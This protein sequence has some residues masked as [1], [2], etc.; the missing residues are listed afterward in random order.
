ML[1]LFLGL[2]PAFYNR[3]FT[4]IAALLPLMLIMLYFMI[5][6]WSQHFYKGNSDSPKILASSLPFSIFADIIV[7][8]AV[9]WAIR[10]TAASASLHRILVAIFLQIIIGLLLIAL[11]AASLLIYYEISNGQPEKLTV[12]IIQFIIGF[13]IFSSIICILFASAFVLIIAHRISWPLIDRLIYSIA[14][15][16]VVK[17]R[18]LLGAFATACIVFAFQA[19]LTLMR[20]FITT[21]GA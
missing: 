6:I 17:N 21:L 20:K 16:Q 15:H 4:R 12:R 8:A 1:C 7:T 14:K 19:D 2:W 13:N 11:P 10:F 3:T 9:R 5:S 18:K